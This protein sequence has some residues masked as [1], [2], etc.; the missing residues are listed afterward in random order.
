MPEIMVLGVTG[1]MCRTVGEMKEKTRL[2]DNIDSK[3]CRSH[4][5]KSFTSRHMMLNYIRVYDQMID[6][7]HAGKKSRPFPVSSG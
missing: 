6:K 7:Y 1:F 4:V 2:V 5:E 3:A